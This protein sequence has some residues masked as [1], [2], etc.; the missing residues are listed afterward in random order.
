AFEMMIE[1]G[2]HFS[3]IEAPAIGIWHFEVAKR[4]IVGPGADGGRFNFR[5]MLPWLDH[6]LK[7]TS[8]KPAT[9]VSLYVMGDGEW[10]QRDQ[11]PDTARYHTY[12]LSDLEAANTCNGGSLA[13]Q[14]MRGELD[15]VYD[16][17]NPV[18]TQGGA[19]LWAHIIPGFEGA[20]PSNVSQDGLCERDDVLTF[21][22][23]PL[24]NRLLISGRIEVSLDVASTAPDTAFT[25]KLIEVFPDGSAYNIRD[26]I[27]SLAYRNGGD[28]P[29]D[30]TPGERVSIAFDIWPVVWHTQVGSK[31]RLD[32]SSSD[33]PKFHAH[34]NRAGPWAEQTGADLATQTVFGGR[35]NIPVE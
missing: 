2:E 1:P 6:H 8:P 26:S 27:T 16:P 21:Q 29:L 13:P 23:K 11:W 17:D 31:L 4:P 18:P 33:F 15:F 20:A 14:P 12:F 32:V 19:G 30:Y 34:T 25:A 22:T 10:Q 5:E 24:E 3:E 9:G 35:I 28:E 7:G